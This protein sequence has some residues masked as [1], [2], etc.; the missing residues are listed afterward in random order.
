MGVAS[1]GLGDADA[2]LSG[3]AQA[4]DQAVRE[5]INTVAERVEKAAVDKTLDR[6]NIKRNTLQQSVSLRR[7][8]AGQ[9]SATVT[10]QVKAI[11]FEEFSPTVRMQAVPVRAFGRYQT[12]RM[13][14][15]VRVKYYKRGGAKLVPGAFP[16][17]QR[18]GGPLQTGDRI[19]RR[20]G[21][22][23]DKLTVLRYFTF[24][25]R[26]LA[27][28]VPELE[29]LAGDG[30]AVEFNPAWRSALQGKSGRSGSYRHLR[31]NRG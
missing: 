10:L 7:A 6:Y 22:A 11:P 20:T 23:R 29:K 16:L 28:L 4:A 9:N 13:Q 12:R 18:S 15:Y 5:S 14:A 24:P 17:R 1:T 3:L 26:H 27:A 31:G 2:M 8:S 25:K 30:V 21:A 19:R